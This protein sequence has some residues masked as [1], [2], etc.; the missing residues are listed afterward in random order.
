MLSSG[1]GLVSSCRCVSSAGAGFVSALPLASS[2]SSLSE[3]THELAI[4]T[5]KKKNTRTP[6]ISTTSLWPSTE[7]Q[8]CSRNANR[9]G[10]RAVLFSLTLLSSYLLSFN[11]ES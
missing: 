7:P 1:A 3:L 4:P 6:S 9:C 2:F 8:M 10:G 11:N 5:S